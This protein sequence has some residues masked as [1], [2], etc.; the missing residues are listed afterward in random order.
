MLTY[1]LKSGI[2]A[3]QAAPAREQSESPRMHHS[4][5]RD[6]GYPNFR[7]P[8]YNSITRRQY[9]SLYEPTLVQA[10]KHSAPRHTDCQLSALPGHPAIDEHREHFADP[11]FGT[12]SHK[13][14]IIRWVNPRPML[15]SKPSALIC[16]RDMHTSTIAHEVDFAL[17]LAFQ[18][19]CTELSIEI[20][21]CIEHEQHSEPRARN[22]LYSS[23]KL[24]TFQPVAYKSDLHGHE[25]QY[26]S[27]K[28]HAI[29]PAYPPPLCTLHIR[30]PAILMQDQGFLH[31]IT[32]EFCI[33]GRY[34]QKL[35]DCHVQA[36]KLDERKC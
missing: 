7:A 36:H 25:I 15:D 10:L 20:S 18:A 31:L 6:V 11:Y 32:P 29:L 33:C 1:R 9:Q 12:S 27:C 30:H 5:L 3:S 26:T 34:G 4:Q 17:K 16:L 22:K 28:C 14:F 35:A 8:F 19:S 24:R 21:E 23:P 13:S 2:H